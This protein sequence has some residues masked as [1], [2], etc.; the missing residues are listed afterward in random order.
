MHESKIPFPTIF[1]TSSLFTPNFKTKGVPGLPGYWKDVHPSKTKLS[2]GTFKIQG[3][4][5]HGHSTHEDVQ[6]EKMSNYSQVIQR[7][8]LYKL[9]RK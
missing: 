6:K 8:M 4:I 1:I 5:P 2:S 3:P 9:I 7:K